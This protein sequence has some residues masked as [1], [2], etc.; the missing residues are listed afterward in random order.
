M[1]EAEEES[2]DQEHGSTE[3]QGP[4]VQIMPVENGYLITAYNGNGKKTTMGDM[5]SIMNQ[6]FGA[7]NSGEDPAQAFKKVVD[8]ASMKE[9]VKRKSVEHHV[10]KNVDETLKL[11]GEILG[12]MKG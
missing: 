3:P 2:M 4:M 8:Q 12:S 11:V 7:M 10:S 5:S 1:E 9:A 6:I